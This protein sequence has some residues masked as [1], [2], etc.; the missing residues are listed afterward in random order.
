MGC[1]RTT[2]NLVPIVALGLGGCGDPSGSSAPDAADGCPLPPGRS[3]V[4]KILLA[5]PG[6]GFDLNGDG[7]IDN[8]FGNLPPSLR[9]SLNQDV[10]AS[11]D[12]GSQFFVL[13]LSN[14]S[15]P[16]T[17]NDGDIAA[18]I[19]LGRDADTELK[20]NFDGTGKFYADA[21]SFDLN[22]D[23]RIATD[24]ASLA[25][26]VLT[27]SAQSFEVPFLNWQTLY[28]S[29]VRMAATFD[30]DY[31]FASIVTG[32]TLRFC[33]LSQSNLSGQ[34]GTLLELLVN[35]Q[36]SLGVSPDIDVDGDGLEQ[37]MTDGVSVTECIDGDGTHILGP[38]CA[39]DPR[40]QDGYSLTVTGDA[41]L[42]RIIGTR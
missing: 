29:T 3:Y 16:P 10:E 27:A 6:I 35:N 9:D 40:I 42:V 31:K 22:C 24:Q 15:D 11:F 20:N 41:A 17:A 36:A 18:R 8:S 7:T 34:S 26:G 39:C 14:W 21:L 37:V 2:R 19:I 38:S 30:A 5:G 13:H 33:T 1:V 23:L 4:E 32:G 28:F 25:N 12:V